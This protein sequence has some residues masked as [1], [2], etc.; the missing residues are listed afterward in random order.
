MHVAWLTFVRAMSEAKPT[1]AVVLGDFV[2]KGRTLEIERA[3]LR[4]IEAIYR[5][6]AGRRYH[7]IGNHDVATFTKAQFVDACGMPGAHYAFDAG[8]IHCVV[9]DAN[10]RKDFSPYKAGNFDWK[11]TY[12]PPNEQK[13]L[14]DDLKRTSRKTLVFVHQTLDDERGAHGVKNAPEVRRLLE[15]SG[16]VL[17]VFQG[18]NHGGKYRRIG[19]I[20]YFTM[21]AMVEGAGLKNNAFA[22]A[23]VQA[24]RVRIRGFGKQPNRP[25]AQES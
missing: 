4:R 19:G 3:Y 11:E 9:L 17:A 6:F 21:R 20:D 2:D 22:L 15:K 8:E 5:K 1:F 10:Y 13:W 18:H 16:R 7:V 24:G 14:A 25:G 23:T 12:I